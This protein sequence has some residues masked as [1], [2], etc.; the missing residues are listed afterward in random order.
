M[1][2]ISGTTRLLAVLGDPVRQVRAPAL[3]NPL[4]D[5]LGLDMVLVP[6]HVRPA[7]LGEVVGGLRRIGNLDGLLVTVPHKFA[8][9]RYADELAP[10]AAFTGSANAL[11]REPEG[12]WRADNFDGVGFVRGLRGAGHEPGGRRF[13]MVGAGGAGTA[14]AAA[15]LEA[16][17]AHL[18]VCDTDAGRLEALVA[19][20]GARWPGR[21]T[22]SA[23]PR[24]EEA[25]I[26]VNATPLGL[27]PA[28]PLPFDPR[29]LPPGGVVADIV[30]E[31]RETPLLRTAAALG[32]AVHH[33]SHTL[34]HQLECYRDFFRLTD[35]VDRIS[36]TSP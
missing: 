21:V 8:I 23:E 35:K 26:A 1:G 9:C 30:M 18:A 12:R 28:D 27:R 10:A 13:A 14:L 25:D 2:R 11:R 4:L 5:R 29:A 34:D 22:G 24:L 15:V 20:L 36:R 31:P 6:M 32:L 3:V 19:R 33:G 7:D 17:A 16:G